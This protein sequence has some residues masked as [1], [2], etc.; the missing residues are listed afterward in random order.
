MGCRNRSAAQLRTQLGRIQVGISHVGR[1]MLPRLAWS[2][3]LF[4]LIACTVPLEREVS[5]EDREILEAAKRRKT[6]LDDLRRM[7]ATYVRMA[8]VENAWTHHDEGI[9]N[10]YSNVTEIVIHNSSHFDVS[11]IE[12]EFTYHGANDS[13]LAKVPVKLAGEVRAGETTRL[14]ADA[15][16]IRGAAKAGAFR[17]SS[18]RVRE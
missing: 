6:E 2:P 13:V 15:R 12:G 8:H 11:D 3:V 9:I 14:K 16:T 18:V 7:P 4:S 1:G 5:R 10:D 17:V